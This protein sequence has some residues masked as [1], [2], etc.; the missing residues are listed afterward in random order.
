LLDS[1]VKDIRM[2]DN[3]YVEINAADES[4]KNLLC[5]LSRKDL[6]DCWYQNKRV[7]WGAGL[8]LLWWTAVGRSPNFPMPRI[9]FQWCCVTEALGWSRSSE[10][11]DDFLSIT[12]CKPGESSNS[13]GWAI[14][15]A[16]SWSIWL[17]RNDA[18]FNKIL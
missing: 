7:S 6:S 15:G 10:S 9:K 12:M 14:F 2:L 5:V 8:H 17:T 18:V 1:G 3:R 13:I 4:K 16:L 11:F